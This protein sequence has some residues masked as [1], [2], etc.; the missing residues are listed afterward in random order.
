ML[1]VPGKAL[2]N[3]QCC[4][5]FDEDKLCLEPGETLERSGLKNSLGAAVLRMLPGSP[6]YGCGAIGLAHKQ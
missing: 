3:K 6:L 4:G 2:K 5:I 1:P